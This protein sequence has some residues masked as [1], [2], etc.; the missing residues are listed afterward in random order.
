MLKW[1]CTDR[2]VTTAVPSLHEARI[3][4]VFERCLITYLNK[5]ILGDQTAVRPSNQQS[6]VFHMFFVAWLARS[7]VPLECWNFP[8]PI[9]FADLRYGVDRDEYRNHYTF[10]PSVFPFFASCKLHLN[11]TRAPHLEI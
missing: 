1:K 9:D 2:K 3:I 5:S 11:H 4:I 10:G 8:F 6:A 7:P